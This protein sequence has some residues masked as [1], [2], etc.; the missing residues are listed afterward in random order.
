M[1]CCGCDH[2]SSMFA[3]IFRPFSVYIF[4]VLSSLDMPRKT[5][6]MYLLVPYHV[7]ALCYMST[8]QNEC[9]TW[10]FLALMSSSC[11]LKKHVG[12]CN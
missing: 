2:T 12:V 4:Y 3:L 5:H 8:H 6:A 9:S 1:I 10:V 7:I 11:F